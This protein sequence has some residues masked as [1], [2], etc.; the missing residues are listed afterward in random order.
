MHLVGSKD[1]PNSELEDFGK[2]YARVKKANKKKK[3]KKSKNSRSNPT[4]RFQR[5]FRQTNFWRDRRN[6]KNNAKKIER[7]EVKRGG[8]CEGE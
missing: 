6:F 8:C 3:N 5:S 1:R 7:G 4:F 2:I